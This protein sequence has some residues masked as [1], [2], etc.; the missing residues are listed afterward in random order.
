MKKVIVITG[1]SA[2]MGKDAALALIKKGHTVY[3][4]ARSMDKMEEIQK[5]G[6]HPIQLDITN[7]Q[8]IK[9]AVDTIIQKEGRIDVLWNNAGYG[10]YGAVE[11]VPITE[12]RHQFE[13][14][15][16][17]LAAITQLVLPHMRKNKSGTII[18]TSSMG[19]RIYMPLG[20]WYHASKHALEGWSDSLRVD[21][22]PFGINV[23]VL[24]PGA[25]ATEWGGIMTDNLSTYSGKGAYS[26]TAK[27]L[28]ASMQNMNSKNMMS[29]TSVITKTILKIIESKKPKTRYVVGA[30]AKPMMWM[31]KHLG[32]TMFD[33]ILMS[34][35]K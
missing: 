11:D 20:A 27:K 28:T 30:M 21:L 4:L 32:D 7:E 29:P 8:Q 19:G 14:N 35:L 6:G 26:D 34:Q 23:V 2:G 18:N 16:F 33:K 12:A 5:V 15:L 13:V 24:Q 17:G 25:I 1:A 31:R 22:R 9:S 3:T 10:L